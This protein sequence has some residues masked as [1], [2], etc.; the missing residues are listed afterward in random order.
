MK[1]K[2]RK[3][4]FPKKGKANFPPREET[5]SQQMTDVLASWPGTEEYEA[6]LGD[7]VIRKK[8]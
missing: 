4:N 1:K 3:A 7:K 8:E 2:R 5:S 6:A